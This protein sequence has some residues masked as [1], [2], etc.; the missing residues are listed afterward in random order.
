MK[1][2]DDE[3]DLATPRKRVAFLPSTA[4]SSRAAGCGGARRLLRS[5]FAQRVTVSLAETEPPL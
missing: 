3:N 2:L 1:F 4:V 5:T